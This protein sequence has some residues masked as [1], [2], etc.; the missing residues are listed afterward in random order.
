MTDPK[1]LET[2]LHEKAG[3]AY[4]ALKADPARAVTAGPNPFDLGHAAP[5]QLGSLRDALADAAQRDHLGA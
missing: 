5:G 1:H 3:P 2:W 4:D